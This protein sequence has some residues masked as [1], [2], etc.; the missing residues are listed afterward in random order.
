MCIWKY[1]CVQFKL[2]DATKVPDPPSTPSFIRRPGLQSSI[3][4]RPSSAP[5]ETADTT[6]VT[7]PLRRPKSQDDKG[8]ALFKFAVNYKNDNRIIRILC[9][10][11]RFF[12]DELLYCYTALCGSKFGT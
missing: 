10:L 2:E 7:L 8:M 1:S 12:Y 9:G 5:V 4:S 11:L 3:S 6:T